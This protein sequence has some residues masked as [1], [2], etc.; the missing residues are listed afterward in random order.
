MNIPCKVFVL[1]FTK[2]PDAMERTC[3]EVERI[4][5]TPIR[6]WNFPTPYT[7]FVQKHIVN[8]NKAM[9]NSEAFFNSGWGHYSILSIARDLGDVP[10]FVV[11]DDC[12]FLKDIDALRR[13][14][15]CAPDDADLLLLD[16]FGAARSQEEFMNERRNAVRGWA[17]IS[18]A[19]SAAAYIVG[20]RYIDRLISLGDRCTRGK[21]A[22][23]FDQWFE[24]R[25]L[26]GANI[27]CAVPNL[28]VQAVDPTMTNRPSAVSNHNKYR[29]MG[30]DVGKYAAW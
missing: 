27:Y 3:A 25:W 18:A 4:G 24:N 8:A 12:R 17:K 2:N 6:H 11:E 1:G 9:K 21:K 30:I 22:R 7:K 28:S 26:E 13:T 15:D 29:E 14:L 23:I 16:S 20:P 19:R 10:V 5:L